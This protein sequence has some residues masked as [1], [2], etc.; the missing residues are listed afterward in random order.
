VDWAYDLDALDWVVLAAAL[1]A[2][3]LLAHQWRMAAARIDAAF[4]ATTD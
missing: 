3:V 2:L 4:D 1:V